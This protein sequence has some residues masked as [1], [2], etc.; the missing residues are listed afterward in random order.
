MTELWRSG[1]LAMVWLLSG[2]LSPGPFPCNTNADC[3]PGGFC[4]G[5]TNLCSFDDEACASGRKYGE[6]A[7][8]LSNTCTAATTPRPLRNACVAGEPF[9]EVQPGCTQTVCARV[10]A[11]CTSL[12]S[13]A[14]VRIA[15]QLCDDVHCGKWLAT[16]AAGT[17]TLFAWNGDGFEPHG[18]PVDRNH[19]RIFWADARATLPRLV[20]TT[21]RG[22][23]V[24][25][26][27]SAT[28][29]EFELHSGRVF[30]AGTVPTVAGVDFDQDEEVEIAV[31]CQGGATCGVFD[32]SATVLTRA[33]DLPISDVQ[34]MSWADAA[35]DDRPDVAVATN[36]DYEVL[37]RSGDSFL[38]ATLDAAVTGPHR[39]VGWGDIDGDGQLDLVA[40]GSG[41]TVHPT[42][43]H[44]ILAPSVLARAP[45]NLL[46]TGAV[47]DIDDDGKAD[48]VVATH[49][50]AVNP[51]SSIEGVIVF[52]HF[53]PAA[54]PM[55]AMQSS[56]VIPAPR[57]STVALADIND[58]GRLDVIGAA[59][60]VGIVVLLN[61]GPQG[62][63][64]L[65]QPEVVPGTEGATWFAITGWPE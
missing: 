36:T 57:M 42:V 37:F 17:T 55:T 15:D 54:P 61:L 7:G 5:D 63:I 1:T 30:E 12:W 28:E 20:A 4:E 26:N 39:A 50:D 8:A 53:D 35:G 33:I 19:D 14:C 6:H 52:S 58:D 41:I 10:P 23:E 46:V 27:G 18:T 44:V 48:I 51:G 40:M 45:G 24:L 22:L 60:G 32:Q 56:T 65:Q 43:D 11:C 38:P 3:G 49:V 13:E 2:C 21:G 16:T 25:K 64:S 47:G 59:P 62:S 9:P 31:G 29:P 34:A